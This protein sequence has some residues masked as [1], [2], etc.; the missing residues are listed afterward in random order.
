[1]MLPNRRPISILILWG[2]SLASSAAPAQS[3]TRPPVYRQPSAS[4]DRR[5]DDLMHRMTLA[6]KVRQLDLYKGARDLMDKRIDDSHAA[7]DAVFRADQAETLFGDLGVGGIHDL[8]PT[9]E[10]ANAIQK[11]VVTHNRLGIPAL[12][13]AEALH[14][15]DRGTV[16]PSAIGL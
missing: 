14:A 9:P 15:Y 13:I 7:T 5:V 6:E 4:V 8:Y 11:W 1:M 2:V 10:Q 3:V 16:F 12:F